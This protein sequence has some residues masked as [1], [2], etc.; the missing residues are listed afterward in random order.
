MSE[1]KRKKLLIVDDNDRYAR[2]MEGFFSQKKSYLIDRANC[3]QAAL[4]IF[5]E[6]GYAY[7]DILVTDIT[8]E[9]Q[10]IGLSMVRELNHRGFRGTTIVASTGF[11]F[12]GM[13]TLSCFFLRF[14]RVHYIVP[15]K[16]V[17]DNNILFY[18]VG[19]SS[20]NLSEFEERT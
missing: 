12:P 19:F 20:D 11:D 17:I 1:S 14:L 6:R 15:K 9:T 8:M 2:L 10:L 7:Y 13:I 16:T 3:A 5:A 4:S 18:P